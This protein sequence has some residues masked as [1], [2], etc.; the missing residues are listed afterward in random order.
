[1]C[2]NSVRLSLWESAWVWHRPICL[3]CSH[4]LVV[5]GLLETI[6]IHPVLEF[7]SPTLCPKTE[8]WNHYYDLFPNDWSLVFSV[9]L[10]GWGVI[11]AVSWKSRLKLNQGNTGSDGDQNMIPLC[12]IVGLVGSLWV[13]LDSGSHCGRFDAELQDKGLCSL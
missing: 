8:F 7:S 11:E 9:S 6:R 3:L 5:T 1:M 10:V 12:C 13:L 4:W 2:P